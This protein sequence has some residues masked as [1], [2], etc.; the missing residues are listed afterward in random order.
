MF[1][2]EKK[3]QVIHVRNYQKP[4]SKKLLLCCEKE[5]KYVSDYKYLGYFMNEH[6]SPSQNAEILT[7]AASRSFGRIVNIFRKLKNMGSK[8]YETLFKT[9]VAPVM[10][11]GSAVWGF[12]EHSDPQVLQNRIARFYLGVLRFTAVPVTSLEMDWLDAKFLRWVEII[13]YRNRLCNMS[14]LNRDRLPVIIH[15]WDVS[16]NTDAWAKSANHILQY[17]NM[18]LTSEN[19]EE[20]CTDLEV[21]E[22]RLLVLNRVK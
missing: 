18:E 8:T 6:L 10:N 19:G 13:R 1:I 22:A 7:A 3:S 2:N 21:L 9:Y 14:R 20:L 15:N 17:A 5:I 12:G 16:L 4:R 11:Y